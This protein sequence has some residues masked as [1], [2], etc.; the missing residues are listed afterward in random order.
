MLWC[1][2][3]VDSPIDEMNEILESRQQHAGK[4]TYREVVRTSGGVRSFHLTLLPFTHL[5]LL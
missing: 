4:R 3:E 1:N 5:L 2:A